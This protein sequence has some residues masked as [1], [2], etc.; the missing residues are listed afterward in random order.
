[1]LWIGE[2]VVDEA[3]GCQCHGDIRS[4]VDG[5]IVEVAGAGS[6]YYVVNYVSVYNCTLVGGNTF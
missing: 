4:M 2:H 3:L 5:G 1:M 6:A